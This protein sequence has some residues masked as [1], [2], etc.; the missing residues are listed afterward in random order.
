MK[1]PDQFPRQN[2]GKDFAAINAQQDPKQA[3]RQAEAAEPQSPEDVEASAWLSRFTESVKN[4]KRQTEFSA[5][6][7]NELAEGVA[8]PKNIKYEIEKT[9][10]GKTDRFQD[11]GDHYRHPKPFNLKTLTTELGCSR[12]EAAAVLS[13]IILLHAK[14]E[15]GL[16]LRSPEIYKNLGVN[17]DEAALRSFFRSEDFIGAV[18]NQALEGSLPVLAAQAGADGVHHIVNYLQIFHFKPDEAKLKEAFGTPARRVEFRRFMLAD[19][20]PGLEVLPTYEFLFG[21]VSSAEFATLFP[22]WRTLDGRQTD[23][24]RRKYG[25]DQPVATQV[26]SPAVSNQ[27]IEP[28]IAEPELPTVPTISEVPQSRPRVDTA[29]NLPGLRSTLKWGAV[30][31]TL[32][33]GFATTAFEAGKSVWQSARGESADHHEPSPTKVA[34]QER[35]SREGSYTSIPR[36]EQRHG[37]ESNNISPEDDNQIEY[38]DFVAEPAMHGMRATAVFTTIEPDG[39]M[40]YEPDHAFAP[41]V[42]DLNLS[43]ST[44]HIVAE[45]VFAQGNVLYPPEL[46]AVDPTSIYLDGYTT[47]DYTVTAGEQGRYAVT[48]NTPPTEPFKIVYVVKELQTDVVLYNG[49]KPTLPEINN[50]ELVEHIKAHG[51]KPYPEEDDMSFAIRATS[52]IK[53]EYRYPRTTEEKG[54]GFNEA[55]REHIGDCDVSNQELMAVLLSNDIDAEVVTD[56]VPVPGREKHAQVR[57]LVYSKEINDT[58]LLSLNATPGEY[59]SAGDRAAAAKTEA[60]PIEAPDVSQDQAELSALIK[61]YEAGKTTVA[62]PIKAEPVPA[63]PFEPVSES[64][65]R[66]FERGLYGY[67]DYLLRHSHSILPTNKAERVRL[68]TEV[69]WQV[70][71]ELEYKQLI[72]AEQNPL[73]WSRHIDEQRARQVIT[74]INQAPQIRTMLERLPKRQE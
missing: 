64:E 29:P 41:D 72:P 22:N 69:M 59:T 57:A 50:P 37:I 60:H 47:S 48:L 70:I 66:A 25:F 61:K 14:Y 65:A 6:K 53:S 24:Y 43:P 16:A 27:P 30:A 38:G 74:T 7:L 5:K 1:A 35:R 33:T 28:A 52:T 63:Q 45:R 23:I 44:N 13:F 15:I 21:A 62:E 19:L 31:V 12:K 2:K 10:G 3:K 46:G 71:S 56:F 67:A 68:T 26:E 17:I 8:I 9:F 40:I 39:G 51:L 36:L 73:E 18:T 11:K 42:V 49:D 55:V 58:V 34:A 20:K 4:G 54:L 32:C